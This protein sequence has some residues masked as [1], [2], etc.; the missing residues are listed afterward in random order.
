MAQAIDIN[1]TYCRSCCCDSASGAQQTIVTVTYRAPSN[2]FALVGRILRFV[3]IATPAICL[4][5]TF[6]RSPKPEPSTIVQVG[7]WVTDVC[8]PQR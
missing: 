2:G 5:V 6:E 4:N 1:T 3:A 8:R 7:P